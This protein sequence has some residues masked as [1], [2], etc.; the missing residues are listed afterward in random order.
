MNVFIQFAKF[1]WKIKWIGNIIS[2][3]I[4]A[5]GCIMILLIITFIT[6]DINILIVKLIIWNI[7]C[8][9]KNR[10]LTIVDQNEIFF[11]YLQKKRCFVDFFSNKSSL[12]TSSSITELVYPPMHVAIN[13]FIVVICTSQ[14]LI[15]V[16][17]PFPISDSCVSVCLSSIERF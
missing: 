6:C 14:L 8:Y 1:T 17:I 7:F 2:T 3:S 9:H 11:W 16:C 5:I 13:V 15:L 4:W 10:I 12:L